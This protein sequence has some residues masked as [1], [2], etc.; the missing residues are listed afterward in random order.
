MCTRLCPAS[1]RDDAPDHAPVPPSSDNFT[2]SLGLPGGAF[3]A[4]FARAAVRRLLT[5][6][7]L[8]ELVDLTELTVSEL[9]SSAYLYTPNTEVSLW[10]RW[11]FGELRLTVFDQHTSHLI[12]QARDCQNERCRSLNLL[13]RVLAAC[14]GDWGIEQRYPPVP[15]T[16]LWASLRPEGARRFAAL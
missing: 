16:S 4:S 15:G 10:L 14:G 8:D 3:C 1:A 7:Q 13:S 2:Y 6:H 9:L 11:R 12:P 5:L